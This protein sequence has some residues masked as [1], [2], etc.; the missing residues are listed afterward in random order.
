MYRGLSR[1]VYGRIGSAGI[2]YVACRW[3]LLGSLLLA[4][5]VGRAQTALSLAETMQLGMRYNIELQTALQ[6]EAIAGSNRQFGVP[7][8]VPSV[9]LSISQNNFLNQYNSP[10]S[11]V[12][13]IYQ[14]NSLNGGVFGSWLLYNGGRV[15]LV[16]PGSTNWPSRRLWKPRPRASG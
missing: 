15:G 6:R 10:T 12:R 13:G 14:D 11:Y 3:W 7:D 16:R 9:D 4:G 1:F 8:R 5:P 2:R